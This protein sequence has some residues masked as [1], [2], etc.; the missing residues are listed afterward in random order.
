MDLDHPD[1]ITEIKLSESAREIKGKNIN[2]DKLMDNEITDVQ[3]TSHVRGC[4]YPT[5]LIQLIKEIITKPNQDMKTPEFLFDM[6]ISSAE[7]N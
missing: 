1:E 6:S 3:I 5:N 2:S 4:W 7:R